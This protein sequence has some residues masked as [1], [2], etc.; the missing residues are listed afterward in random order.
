MSG[1][2]LVALVFALF[3]PMPVQAAPMGNLPPT[4]SAELMRGNIPADAVSVWVQPVDADQP[5]LAF[6]AERPMNPASVMKLVTTFAALEVLGPE[7]TW[8]TRIAIAAS[9][10]ESG[11]PLGSFYLVGDGDPMLTYERLWRILRRLR[12]MGY[13]TIEGDIVLDHSALV[14]PPHDPNAFDGKGLRPYNGSGDGLLIHFNTQQLALFPGRNERDPVR[15]VAEPPLWGVEIDNQL[16]TSTRSCEPWHRDLEAH[17][18]KNGRLTLTGSLPAGCGPRM[19]A[20]SPLDPSEYGVAMVRSLWWELGGT[21]RG[22][23][24]NGVVPA[25]AQVLIFDESESLGVVVRTM[26]KWSSNVLARQLLALVGRASLEMGGGGFA[27]RSPAADMVSA[28]ADAARRSLA[29]A[30]INVSGLVIENGSGLSR[31]ERIRAD[32]LGALL[33]RAWQRPWMPDFVASLPVAGLDGTVRR[34]L[35]DSPVRGHA[36]LKTGTINDV[37]SIAGYVL[38]RNGRRHAVVMMINHPEAVG[39]QNAQD[40]LIEWVWSGASSGASKPASRR[41]GR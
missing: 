29:A 30:G 14:M 36:H 17:F 41:S 19:W 8:M 33:I 20:N 1:F 10:R 13:S 22:R 24:R 18:G 12:S 26:N 37:K 2:V 34:R 7:R 27:P 25:E 32:S 15:L 31:N 21:V 16:V 28:G 38:D 9:P 11:A 4:V 40:A 3:L 35:K 5:A 6:N 23:V 39:S